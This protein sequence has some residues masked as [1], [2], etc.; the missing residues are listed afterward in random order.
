MRY[1]QR[2]ISGV[3]GKTA[4]TGTL[5]ATF[6]DDYAH[7]NW[8]VENDTFSCYIDAISGD[9]ITCDVITWGENPATYSGESITLGEFDSDPYYLD[10][11]DDP[12]N[13]YIQTAT[14][15]VNASLADGRGIDHVEIDGMQFYW[16]ENSRGFDPEATGHCRGGLP[17]I[18]GNGPELHP[19]A[20]GRHGRA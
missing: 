6:S 4:D 18:H 1:L 16:D 7:A 17:C 2:T 8:G 14:D 10:L 9:V 20:L 13:I 19:H 11:R 5:T 15:I 12:E 3:F